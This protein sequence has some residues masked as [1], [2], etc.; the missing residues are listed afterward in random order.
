MRIDPLYK[1]DVDDTTCVSTM[2]ASQPFDED[3]NTYETA[4]LR[5]GGRLRDVEVVGRASTSYEATRLHW[6]TVGALRGLPKDDT[7]QHGTPLR[8]IRIREEDP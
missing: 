5:G 4:I 6:E 3:G 1:T 2:V 8:A 7:P